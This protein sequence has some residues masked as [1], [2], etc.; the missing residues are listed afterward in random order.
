MRITA[1]FRALMIAHLFYCVAPAG[2]A[3]YTL[4]DSF[5]NEESPVGEVERL[6]KE[7]RQNQEL[8]RRIGGHY[9][10]IIYPVQLRHH[11]KMGISTREVSPPKP[12][13]RPGRPH[14]DGGFSRG[15]TKKH[16]HRTSLLIKAF[17]HKF[18]LDLELNSQLLSPNIQQ[19]HYHVGGYL[20]DGNRHD[21]E[22]C[23]YHGTVKDYPGA[24]AAFHTCNGVSGVI[25]IGNETF[26]IH[27]FYGGDL[28]KHPHVIF[29]ART[30]ANKGCA[31]SGNLESWR[32]SR[33][34]KHLSGVIDDIHPNG[35]GRYKRD[36]REATKYI[37]TAIIVD[38]AMFE[39]RNG[40][41]RADV[42][43]DAIQ[44]ANIA[45]L[46]FRTLNTRVSVVYIETWGKNQAV[47]DGSKDISKAISNFND[48]TSRNLFQIE[49]DTT[50]LLT[51]ETFAGGEAGMAVPETVCTPRAVG[52]SVDINVYEPHLLAGTMA[53]MIG[54]NIG[55]GH[56]DGREECFCRDWHGCIM[57]QSIVG[58]ENVQPYKFSECS[59]KDY[60]DAL[61]TGHGL[62]LLNKPNEIEM[63]RNC[64]NK[65]VE[66]DEECDCGTFE[67]CAVDPCCD[68]ITCKLKTEAQCATGM[69][70][71]KCRLR[72]KD[73]IC[74]DSITECDLPE[75]CDG[76]NGHCPV[77]VY[78]K[79]GSPCGHTKAGTSGYCF[80]GDCPTL[81]LQ[82][83]GIW[84]Y[85]G[86]AADRQCYEQF[87]SKGSI[88]GH[89]G[90]D[91]NEHYIKC[92]PE[93]VQCGT[94]QC[95]EGERQ[96]INDGIDQLYS[97]TIISIKGVEYECKATSGQVGSNEYPEHGL[98]KDGTPCGDNLICVNQTCVSLF[99]HIDQTKCPANKQ[100][101]EC[102]DHGVCTNTNRCFCDM[103]WGGMDCSLIV[104][105]TTPMPTQ[106]LPT[107]EN[108]I[109]MEKKETPYENYH[110]SNTV[111]LVGVLMSVVGFVFVT[112]TLM[113]LCYRSVVVHRNFSLCLRRKT[114]T[115]KYDPPYLKKPIAKAGNAA[116]H[117][118]VEEVS[119][120]GSSK[121]MY[122]NQTGFRD[123]K[124]P[125]VRRLTASSEEDQ[126]HSEKGILKKHGY[127]LVLGDQAN[128]WEDGQS[129]NLELIAQ[130]DG[131]LAAAT[132]SG[133]AVS[134]VER[135]LKSL[136][137]YH[138][139]ILEALRNAA[140]HRGTGAGN[141]PVGS[142]SLSE[143]MLR[144]T[145]QECST[146]QLSYGEYKRSSSKSGS[147]ENICDIN[148]PHTV[149]V[150][151]PQA[152]AILHHH[153]SQHHLPDED[154]A[155]ATGPLRI[156]NL[157]DLI[158]QLE[159]HSVRHMSPS[160]SEDN[161][162]SETEADRHYRLDSSAA[163]SES[164]QGSNQQLAQSQKTA[165][166]HPSYSRSCRPRSDEESR[167]VYGRYRH[168]TTSRHPHQSHSPHAFGHHTHHSHAHGHATH[169]P[170]SSHHSSHTHLHQDDEG[171]YE[172]AD[173][174]DRTVDARIDRETPD[175]ESDD[176]I[177]AQ[178]QLARWASEDVVSV[179]VLDHQQGT[180]SDSQ[181]PGV[182]QLSTAS[183]SSVIHHHGEP[184]SMGATNGL[185]VSQRDFYPSPPS[186]ETESSGS[187]IQ[188]QLRR[189]HIESNQIGDGQLMEN[190]RYPEYKH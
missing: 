134:E 138:E 8:V 121:L 185:S 83:E 112:F 70:C 66:E 33:R 182:G 178:Q 45:D 80:Q 120:D 108:T 111:F 139:D 9:Y 144:K 154:D 102:S 52:I 143:E 37:E 19:K 133:A 155:P 152:G 34:T 65:I 74:R 130:Q 51:G 3:D 100:G 27:P 5:W 98:V 20:V 1:P 36:V 94:L 171:I 127:G 11:E 14:D 97:R 26:V 30:K 93:N 46:Y 106:A 86:S 167:F 189:A 88:N 131:T 58:Q 2:E 148:Q 82:C 68:G 91:A 72:P 179:V 40:S 24:S 135:T 119:L 99:P 136:N 175:S 160:G 129:D 31:N 85:G 113:A 164:S 64:G 165:T 29:E 146:S 25:H 190:G 186:T 79:N 92:D 122:Q 174:H 81:S 125:Q 103:G 118:S 62:C 42:I 44:V 61:R 47:I 151:G 107:P 180:M 6:L 18:R 170:H 176:F 53:H 75:Y 169:G 28:S 147:K 188:P 77:D 57:A 63:R 95:K 124:T 184:S 140:S 166:I 23:Y 123:H 101:Q 142:G 187:V 59:K 4:D 87:N 114:T 109:K 16:F 183:T 39:K 181:Q 17:N 84:G 153:R 13:Q 56:D 177:Q 132:A 76:D 96:P 149:L 15:R 115:L 104:I 145:L 12:G 116:N 105:L 126:A 48:Y 54:H 35:A 89:C 55:M 50:Q 157:E 67:E 159:H 7:Y 172:S 161:R 41:S 173:H 137:G 73:F 117:H 38:K 163:C 21:I 22:H 32:L 156:R 128:K 49:R 10:Q 141:T 71:D 158:R 60:I 150:E 78:K 90:R 110:G 162:M 69:C 168:P 43:H